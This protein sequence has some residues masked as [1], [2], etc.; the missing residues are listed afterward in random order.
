MTQRIE[1]A[2]ELA[3][4][5]AAAKAAGKRVGFVPTM[6]AL[7][8]GHLEL[9]RQA[10]RATEFVVVS[11]FVNPLQFGPAEDF[12]R[13]PRTIDAD[14][15]KLESA[16]ADLVFLPEAETVYPGWP[17]RNAIAA[18]VPQLTAS[19]VGAKFEGAS[20]P[21]HFD[22]MLTVVSRLFDLVQPDVAYFGAKDAQQ[23]FLVKQMATTRFPQLEIVTV[24][25]V[26]E[27][28]GLAMSSR[29][30]YLDADEHQTALSIS[31]ALRQ[32]VADAQ[33]GGSPSIVLSKATQA[34][35]SQGKAKLD[36]LALVDPK[37]FE[38]IDDDFRGQ[39]LMLIAAKVGTT[40]LI[41]NQTIDF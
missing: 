33:V 3:Q 26:R 37:N 22:G 28:D 15:K 24:P 25:T 31:A 6:G 35:L 21:G 18:A 40:R 7:H 12:E 30:R 9:V 23:V 4:A 38:A 34:M 13:Y 29:N 2:V 41:D 16:D 5:V 32:A 36:Y 1:S 27:R 10:K 19:A 39:A 14:L 20:R 11:I 8:E 17:D